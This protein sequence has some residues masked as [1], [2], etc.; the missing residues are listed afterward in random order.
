MYDRI[1]RSAGLNGE[2]TA[3]W[4]I[5]PSDTSVFTTTST[6]V[7]FTNGQSEA[8]VTVQVSHN[9]QDM[10]KCENSFFYLPYW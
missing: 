4:Q 2:V 7:T 6:V 10:L 5:H 3:T 9:Q 8:L 1:L